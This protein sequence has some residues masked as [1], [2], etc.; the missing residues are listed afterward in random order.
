[1][2]MHSKKRRLTHK[3]GM[4][5]TQ[6]RR[7]SKKNFDIVDSRSYV[8]CC[9]YLARAWTESTRGPAPWST[10]ACLGLCIVGV[11]CCIDGNWRRC[12]ENAWAQGC[13][14]LTTL[15]T[16]TAIVMNKRSEEN[17]RIQPS[18]LFVDDSYLLSP[19]LKHR[20]CVT[21]SAGLIVP[22]SSLQLR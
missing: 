1:M 6:L 12:V 22:L 8:I 3:C 5:H 19:L 4:R 14:W 2:I 11:D 21:R 20:L 17:P 18:G 13:I 10:F 16:C 7:K 15:S 9:I